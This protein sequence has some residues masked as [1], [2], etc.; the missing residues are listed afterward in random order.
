MSIFRQ[1]RWQLTLSYTIVTVSAFLVVLLIMGGV[2]LPR[3]FLPNHYFDPPELVELLREDSAPLWSHILSQSPVD[4]E[5]IRL[6]FKESD[7]TITSSDF[8][9]IGS[10]QFSVKTLA[11]LNALVIG[12]N[13]TLLGKSHDYYLPNSVIGQPF[14]T[15]Q[16]Q[17][18]EEPLNAALAGE[19]DANRLYSIFKP[20]N[21]LLLALPIFHVGGDEVNRVVGVVVVILDPLPTQADIPSH[22]LKI[23]GRSLLIFLLGVGIMGAIFG[24]FFSHGLTTRFK[25]IS[26]TTDLWSAGDFSRYIEDT[27]G[28]EITQFTQRLNSMAKQLQSLLRRRQDMA[29]SE[30]RN[31]LARDLHDSAK[32]QALAAS[33]ELGTALTL[34]EGDPQGAKKH[35]VEAEALVDAVRRELTNLVDEL[36]PQ[37]MGDQDFSETLKEHAMDWS[38]RSGIEVDVM[39]EG[40]D[41]ISLEAQEAL[42]RIAQEA[43]ANVARHSS[44]NSVTVSL[45]YEI[46]TVTM[47]IK[48][49]GCG[50][51]ISTPHGGIGL[52]S[53]RERAEALGGCFT[54]ESAADQ[55]TRIV[56]TLQLAE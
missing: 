33:F 44:A 24:A 14:D 56:V 30:E 23:A 5:L 40:Y 36:R 34:Y 50:F 3:I 13:R 29:I 1:L 15:H 31:R 4:T 55:G 51:D 9:R 7:A 53:M 6:L 12:T 8:L 28:D 22:I 21:R 25:R 49:D 41:E 37:A 39:I 10:M 45:E 35:L 52:A 19:T 43:L 38:Q 20:N 46:N 42:F 17:G 26:A 18:L 54:L 47:I 48:D 32:Q 16:I 2:L 11:V 27:V